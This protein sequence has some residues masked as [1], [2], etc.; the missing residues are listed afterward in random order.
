M[1]LSNSVI[2]TLLHG[3]Q[4]ARIYVTWFEMNIFEIILR[5]HIVL[6]QREP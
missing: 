3:T 5:N 2:T 1:V 6:F 4:R